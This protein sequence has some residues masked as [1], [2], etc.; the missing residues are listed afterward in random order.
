DASFWGSLL[1]QVQTM[2]NDRNTHFLVTLSRGLALEHA[3]EY[4]SARNAY[5][6]GRPKDWAGSMW[7]DAFSIAGEHRCAELGNLRENSRRVLTLDHRQL[8]GALA[9]KYP[10]AAYTA[11]ADAVRS[12]AKPSSVRT[13]LEK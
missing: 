12:A 5:Y 6:Q 1:A 9:K 13:S 7:L 10:R 11:L 4:A 3:H 2:G 8:G